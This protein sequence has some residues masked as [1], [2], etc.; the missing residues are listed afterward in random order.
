MSNKCMRSTYSQIN[1]CIYFCH[2]YIGG[3]Y[4]RAAY[5]N[6]LPRGDDLYQLPAYTNHAAGVAYIR[7]D[8]RP[9]Q[10]VA[11]KVIECHAGAARPY[12]GCNR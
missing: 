7:P 1:I 6:H 11:E 10:Q 4:T 3:I 12:A 2:Q 8:H 9:H 5:N